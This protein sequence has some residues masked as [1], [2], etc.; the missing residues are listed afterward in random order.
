MW[1]PLHGAEHDGHLPPWQEAIGHEI[2][3]DA[4]KNGCATE[5]TTGLTARALRDAVI[6]PVKDAPQTRIQLKAERARGR[7]SGK[8]GAIIGTLFGQ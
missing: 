6:A 1:S 7:L 4:H 2:I 8:A 3:P 5:A